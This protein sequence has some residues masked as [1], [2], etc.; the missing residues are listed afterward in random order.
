MEINIFVIVRSSRYLN[1][2]ELRYFS[3]KSLTLKKG[4]MFVL[5]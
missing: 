2:A 1:A 3:Q 5:D 4:V